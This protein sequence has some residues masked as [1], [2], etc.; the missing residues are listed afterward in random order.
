MLQLQIAFIPAILKFQKK[1]MK[2]YVPKFGLDVGFGVIEL[3]QCLH[4][5]S[6]ILESVPKLLFT[7][8]EN[9]M[10]IPLRP[11]SG[12]PLISD[13]R[14]FFFCQSILQALFMLKKNVF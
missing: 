1:V 8:G 11:R 14:Y 13:K 2:W 5:N 3:H 7:F 6:L 4:L 10:Q 9:S 12:D